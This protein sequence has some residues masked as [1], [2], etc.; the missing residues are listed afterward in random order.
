MKEFFSDIE[1]TS[2]NPAFI[3]EFIEICWVDPWSEDPSNPKL[4]EKAV[5]KKKK[6]GQKEKIE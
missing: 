3:N 5:K 1:S 2:E 6:P 4:K